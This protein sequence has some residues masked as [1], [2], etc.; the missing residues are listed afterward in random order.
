LE[1]IDLNASKTGRNEMK[2]RVFPYKQHWSYTKT[3]IETMKLQRNFDYQNSQDSLSNFTSKTSKAPSQQ[4][5]NREFSIQ[6]TLESLKFP[7]TFTAQIFRFL[8]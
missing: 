1:E 7:Q 2:F 5:M 6:L 3:S 4:V 8:L